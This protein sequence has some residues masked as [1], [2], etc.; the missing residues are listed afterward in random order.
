MEAPHD[1]TGLPTAVGFADM[2]RLIRRRLFLIFVM[3]AVLTLLAALALS[4]IA[5][6]FSAKALIMID[7]RG[8]DVANL[9]SVIAGLSTDPETVMSEIQVL[10][11]QRLANMVINRLDLHALEEFNDALRPPGLVDKLLGAD[12]NGT[13]PDGAAHSGAGDDLISGQRVRILRTFSKRL[14]VEPVPGSRAVAVA[15][16]SQDAITAAQAA[17]TLIDIYLEDQLESKF[18]SVQRASG[19]LNERVASLREKVQESEQRVEAFRQASGLLE[20]GGT[21]LTDQEISQINAQAFAASSERAAAEIRLREVRRLL[22]TED[23]IET[24]GEVLDSSLIQRLREQEAGIRRRMAELA[25]EYGDRHPTMVKLRAEAADLDGKIDA[26]IKKIVSA[27]ENR[28]RI[29]RAN[30]ANLLASLDDAKARV[31]EDNKALVTLRS[32]EREAEANRLVLEGMLTRFTETS[33]QDDLASQRPDARI[34]SRAVVPDEPSYPMKKAILALVF[35]GAGFTGLMLAFAREFMDE[36]LRSGEQLE[37]V[38]GLR[39]LGFIPR[40]SRRDLGEETPLGFFMNEAV[41]P[42]AESFRTLF[43]SLCA[44][45]AAH[46]PKTILITSSYANEGKTT[47]AVC[48]SS[49]IALSGKRVLI[50]DADCRRPG[51]GS[52]MGIDSDVGLIDYL[53]E[54]ASL[55]DIVRRHDASGAYVIVSG[56]ASR[57]PPATLASPRLD[58]LM[59]TLA[60]EYDF[61]IIDSPPTL[62]VSDALVITARVDATIIVARWG[63]TRRSAVRHTV[64]QLNNAGG[65]LAGGLL[66]QVDARKY[67]QYGY[68]DSGSYT[69]KL[70]AYQT[71]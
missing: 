45:R 22:R 52:Q 37:T 40:L 47:V 71:T 39:S 27:L 54:R 43:S 20:G 53:S 46:M 31:G 57:N 42:F 1:S 69:G 3:T 65:N 61:V 5:P 70:G 58:E 41:S 13:L 35:I 9:E 29:A 26:E 12:A 8:T 64:K 2:L 51:V 36:G 23:G 30:E 68:G 16:S 63:S 21:T 66:T 48:L 50:V 4:T 24:A 17:N 38:T 60:S 14:D 56:Q 25:S 55:N 11:S 28:A 44:N 15:F 59:N 67:A 6:R 18:E 62:A 49:L 34:I 7:S 19:W 32:L 10:K 33:E